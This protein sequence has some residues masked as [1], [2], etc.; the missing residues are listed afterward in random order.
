MMSS[1]F[2][3]PVAVEAWDAWFRWRDRG[4]LRDLT[5][6][7]TWERIATSL[8]QKR[9]LAGRGNFRRQLLDAFSAWRLL[10]DERILAGAGT[11]FSGG[12]RRDACLVAV[13]NVAA[14]VR[15]PYTAHAAL[16]F[17]A[18]ESCADLAVRA[19]DEALPGNAPVA[20]AHL[21]IGV[22]GMADAL[23][24]LDVAYDS[25][26]G[27]AHAALVARTLAAGCLRGS[28]AMARERGPRRPAD[29]IWTTRERARA[30]A[31]EAIADAVRCGLRHDTLTAVTSQQRIA[32]FANDVSDALDPLRPRSC[33]QAFACGEGRRCLQ[34]DGYARL[35]GRRIGGP[36]S[37][38]VLRPVSL[39][40]QLQLRA[41][42]Q[43]WIDEPIA[44]PLPVDVQPGADEIAAC[45][46][47]AQELGLKSFAW[48]LCNA[49]ASAG[50]DLQALS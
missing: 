39:I 2:I 43:P 11:A 32:C 40:A 20:G 44:S 15:A 3:S 35:L 37:H 1:P 30:T 47:M 33:T 48:R 19:L 12:A 29:D 45:A 31:A 41:A 26:A 4:E 18:F 8:A 21:R 27:R 34:S 5:I 10:P 36:A 49:K 28:L 25:G 23:A 50:A 22:I 38:P 9:P 17:G 42:V 46:G 6:D 13:L 7:A 14:F 16:D 24:L